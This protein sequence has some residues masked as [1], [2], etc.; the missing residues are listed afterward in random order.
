MNVFDEH[1]L[2]R[3]CVLIICVEDL[4]ELVNPCL[5]GISIIWSQE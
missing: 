3:I 2:L 5:L 4:I 1:L